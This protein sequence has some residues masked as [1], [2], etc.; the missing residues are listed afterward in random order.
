[1]GA[2]LSTSS[3][4]SAKNAVEFCF[5]LKNELWKEC[6]PRK[7]LMPDC[8]L[9]QWDLAGTL[10][11]TGQVQNALAIYRRLLRKGPERI[12]NNP[13]SESKRWAFSM[14][15][16][17]FFCVGVCYQE[18]RNSDKAR[19]AFSEFLQLR[20]VWSDGVY[21]FEDAAKRLRALPSRNPS[22]EIRQ[23]TDSLPVFGG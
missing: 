3:D 10:L 23:A 4:Y 1:M 14:L 13:C 17:C 5:R 19:V 20:S 6:L 12:I 18:L 16:D 7:E 21:S 9:V 11:A 8:P 2:F 22:K 15:V